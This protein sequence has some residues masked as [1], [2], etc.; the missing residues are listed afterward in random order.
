MIV[1]PETLVKEQCQ[2]EITAVL[3]K[4][5]LKLD[6][7]F[8]ITASGMSLGINL[9]PIATVPPPVGEVKADG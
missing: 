3:N 6:P 5:G 1:T 7:F 2:T 9:I 4:Y 8:H